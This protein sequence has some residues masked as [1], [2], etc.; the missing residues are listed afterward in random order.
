MD[1]GSDDRRVSGSGQTPVSRGNEADGTNINMDDK[2]CAQGEPSLAEHVEPC[3]TE[4]ELTKMGL[5]PVP[6]WARKPPRPKV[7]GLFDDE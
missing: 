7:R 5:L 2:E 6:D 4:A 3:F 1:L